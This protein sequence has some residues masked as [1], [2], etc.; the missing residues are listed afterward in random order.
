MNLTIFHQ[1]S[2]FISHVKQL[3]N[4]KV[5]GGGGQACLARK[6]RKPAKPK[7]AISTDQQLPGAGFHV[8][9][10]DGGGE[11]AGQKGAEQVQAAV[12]R[13]EITARKHKCAI[14]QV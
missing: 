10:N 14:S 11:L 7:P 9:S 8:A 13:L 4:R 2:Y 5:G 12:A 1:P 3:E 6:R